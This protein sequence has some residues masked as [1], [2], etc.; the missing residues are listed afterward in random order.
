[1]ECTIHPF[2]SL[3][4]VTLGKGPRDPIV[5]QGLWNFF[6][7]QLPQLRF[8]GC[9]K[10]WLEQLQ[11]A[12]GSHA[13]FFVLQLMVEV[14]ILLIHSCFLHFGG[15]G[16]EPPIVCWNSTFTSHYFAVPTWRLR[17]LQQENSVHV[18][19]IKK[20]ASRSKQKHSC[21]SV[22]SKHTTYQ[23]NCPVSILETT[24]HQVNILS[25]SM[26]GQMSESQKLSDFLV[27]K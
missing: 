15:V 7:N 8:L 5:C 11:W 9:L 26:T 10:N 19:N 1:M 27:E 2:V 6:H 3:D 25:T 22:A 13:A 24:L 20:V 14:E 17:I 23:D 21:D 16:F 12:M 18:Y 4:E